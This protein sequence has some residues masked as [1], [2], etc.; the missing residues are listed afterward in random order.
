M[1]L[2]LANTYTYLIFFI[3]PAGWTKSMLKK[4]TDAS[5]IETM[6]ASAA[7][8]MPAV[9]IGGTLLTAAFSAWV[10]GKMLKKQFEKAGMV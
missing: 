9:I 5:Y 8:W 1:V 7:G 4:G 6:S 10:G 2:M 3:D